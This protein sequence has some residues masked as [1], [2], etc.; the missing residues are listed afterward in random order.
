[1]IWTS[2]A[3]FAHGLLPAPKRVP[4]PGAPEHLGVL[5]DAALAKVPEQEAIIGRYDR[6]TFRELEARA[7][8]GAA[9]LRELG[10]GEGVRVACCAANDAEIVVAFLAVQRLGAIWIGINRNLGP[11]E[12]LYLLRDCGARVFLAEQPF[13]QQ[14]E[15]G[16]SDLPELRA[17]VRLGAT[18]A[19]NQ[20]AP[21]LRRLA[22]ARRPDVEIDPW[23]PAAIAYTSGTTGFPKGAVHSQHNILLAATISEH[24]AID[25]RPEVIRGTASPLTI[26]N[27]MILGPVATLAR[28]A[29]TVCMDRTDAAGV[30]EWIARERINTT[31]LVPTIVKDLLTRPDIDPESL[32]SLT[33]IVIGA[34]MVP[35]GL[36]ALYRAR[37]GHAPTIGYGLTEQP[38]AVTRTHDKTPPVH[39]AI[40]RPLPHL[41]V[42]M[43]DAQDQE[44]PRSTAGEI[45][46]RAVAQ[47]A[48]A[49]VYTPTLGYWNKPEATAALL[50]NG[51][52]HT[53][54]IGIMDAA[55]E[56][57][58]QDRRSNLI[59]RGGANVYPA[60]VE[61]VLRQE[62]R[63]YDCAVIG[64]PDE[65]L[66]QTVAAVIQPAANVP[67]EGLVED[68]EVLCAREIARYKIPVQWRVV[69]E[70]PR[71]ALGKVIRAELQR[72]FE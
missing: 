68:L 56:V 39:G 24:M 13:A 34:A 37:F 8:A 58:I 69:D 3:L 31:S 4:I 1:M 59:V 64:R 63:V 41:Q 44:V 42:S 15:E 32:S 22:G 27:F 72:M 62:R 49:D 61:R 48:W 71:N 60:E 54:D 18:D 25:R 36:P 17:L 20:W 2:E 38:T 9:F 7:N 33:W 28:G 65:R 40:G 70:L 14:A 21:A 26:L 10:V 52:M 67:T 19:E 6:L 50:R 43:L 30:A 55:G 23:A 51:W 5:L 29:R 45:C 66:G 46:V 57:F 12:K 47:G 11:G 35:E 16:R 53:G